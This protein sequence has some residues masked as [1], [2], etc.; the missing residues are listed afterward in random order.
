MKFVIPLVFVLSGSFLGYGQSVCPIE[1][2]KTDGIAG[3]VIWHDKK[4]LPISG[5]RLKVLDARLNDADL[6]VASFVT[7]DDGRF[8][9]NDLKKGKYILSATLFV[10]EKPYFEYRSVFNVRKSKANPIRSVTKLKLG[11]NCWESDV[12]VSK[13]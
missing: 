7:K 5:V 9:F 12:S 10:D 4:E 13:K 8:T 2:L 1:N 6:L 11:I 3:T